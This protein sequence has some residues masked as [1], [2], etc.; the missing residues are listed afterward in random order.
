MKAVFAAVKAA[1]GGS[2]GTAEE[3]FEGAAAL[4]AYGGM[5]SGGM[6]EGGATLQGLIKTHQ[7]EARRQPA[8]PPA[9]APAAN[10]NDWGEKETEASGGSSG[11][12]F[13]GE[14]A[15]EFD[16]QEPTKAV[17]YRADGDDNSSN[18]N[19]DGN[20]GD[21]GDDGS[22]G[23][24]GSDDDDE[25]VLSLSEELPSIDDDDDDGNNNDEDDEGDQSG[26]PEIRPVIPP[27]CVPVIILPGGRI[28]LPASPWQ[29]TDEFCPIPQPHPLQAL[30]PAPNRPCGCSARGRHRNAC[31]KSR[32]KATPVTLAA[33]IHGTQA[34][35][36]EIGERQ[37]TVPRMESRRLEIDMKIDL[38]HTGGTGSEKGGRTGGN[39]GVGGEGRVLGTRK[40]SSAALHEAHGRRTRSKQN[41]QG[42]P[43]GGERG[44]CGGSTCTGVGCPALCGGR[45]MDT[46][47]GKLDGGGGGGTPPSA[48]TRVI[49]LGHGDIN[50]GSGA[51]KCD[52]VPLAP[53]PP[54]PPH[55]MVI[56]AYSGGGASHYTDGWEC[57]RCSRTGH[58]Q[59]WFCHACQ[60]DVCF[61]CVARHNAVATPRYY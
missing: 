2:L 43:D 12:G 13:L 14:A 51:P 38:K 24:D 48:S 50:G 52:N 5:G 37:A 54:L 60:S 30:P 11:L 46:W 18:D 57:D 23:S 32:K 39:D 25:D 31:S 35:G 33:H 4:A 20:D 53:L 29:S 28:P 16:I 26:G 44:E 15:E 9:Y 55:D 45:I 17:R 58:G 47:G 61:D 41:G 1:S 3:V 34:G 49:P 7:N 10:G 59:R 22:D 36:K 6:P 8:Y 19:N 27:S 42:Q 56:S 40:S 21:D